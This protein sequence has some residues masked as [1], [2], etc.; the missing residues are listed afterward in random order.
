MALVK[1][2]QRLRAKPLVLVESVGFDAI[3]V[4]A[5]LF[6]WVSDGD[7]ESEIVVEHVGGGGEVELGKRGI[8]DVKLDPIGA[9]DEPEDEHQKAYNDN[10]AADEFQKETEKAAAAAVPSA[11][12]LAVVGSAGWRDWRAVVGSVQV[13][14]FLCHGNVKEEADTERVC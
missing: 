7:V 10:N 2:G 8:G 5:D 1:R 14:L 11:A 3:V 6:V 4:Y 13:G 9:E 12:A